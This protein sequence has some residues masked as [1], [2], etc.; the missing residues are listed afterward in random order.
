MIFQKL[1]Q[2]VFQVGGQDT[3]PVGSLGNAVH[4]LD[5]KNVYLGLVMMNSLLQ[6]ARQ[7]R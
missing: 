4:H 5:K 6:Q 1:A 2:S 7:S 3:Y